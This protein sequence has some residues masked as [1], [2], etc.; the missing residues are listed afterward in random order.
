MYSK[1]QLSILPFYSKFLKFIL[2]NES[3]N[4]YTKPKFSLIYFIQLLIEKKKFLNVDISEKNFHL[5][6]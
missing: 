6:D 4:L 5:V 1:F 2:N 3:I